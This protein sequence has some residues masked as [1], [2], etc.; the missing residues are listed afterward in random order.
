VIDHILTV[1]DLVAEPAYTLTPSVLAAEAAMHLRVLRYDRAL[2]RESRVRRQ[3]ERTALEKAPPSA[4]VDDVAVEIEAATLVSTAMPLRSLFALL[5]DHEYL[6]MVDGA[7]IARVVTRADLGRPV[8]GLAV[9][10]YVQ[11]IESGLDVLIERYSNGDWEKS[12]SDDRLALARK[13][14]DMRAKAN[15]DTSLIHM[16]QMADR[17]TL[18][19]K[20]SDLHERLGISDGKDAKKL[21]RRLQDLRDNLAHG[22]S[23]LDCAPTVGEAIA[24]V[25]EAIDLAATIQV[26]VDDDPG[27][28]T[29]YL[30]TQIVA[31]DGTVL[32]GP[33]AGPLPWP[34]SVFV[35]SAENPESARATPKQNRAAT[36]LLRERLERTN[37]AFV[38]IAA[39]S[40]DGKWREAGFAVSG[41]T[42]E[43]ASE[44]GRQF[45]QRAVFELTD[46]QIAV[47]MCANG[48]IAARAPRNCA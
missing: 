19:A 12:L 47:V 4:T 9:F 17:F 21:S 25:M 28:L 45:V 10:A 35:L 11:Q 7:Q 3:V 31:D 36:A 39:S 44:L 27:L 6:W 33:D 15:I 41:M 38:S 18:V 14:F 32:R 13:L 26:L 34:G 40:P 42:R 5:R 48:E 23:V 20:L 29:R 22:G 2:V 24:V 8:A 30:Q 1:G 43:Q 46:D 16:V 37:P